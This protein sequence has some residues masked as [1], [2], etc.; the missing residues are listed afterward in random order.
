MYKHTY[1]S[2]VRHS[3]ESLC[4]KSIFGATVPPTGQTRVCRGL[5]AHV[6]AGAL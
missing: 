1:N 6:H 4:V 5:G 3:E 2:S